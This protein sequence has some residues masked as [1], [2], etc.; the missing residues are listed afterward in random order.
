MQRNKTL[1]CENTTKEE[2]EI[3]LLP[4]FN[5]PLPYG[6]T[7]MEIRQRTNLTDLFF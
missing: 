7:I 5:Y 6:N 2:M 3:Q 1:Y 4:F